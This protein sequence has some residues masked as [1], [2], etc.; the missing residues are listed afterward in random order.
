M[1]AEVWLCT[2]LPC[3]ITN[4]VCP[5]QGSG[6]GAGIQGKPA[7]NAIIPGTGTRGETGVFI[8]KTSRFKY[9]FKYLYVPALTGPP[10][11][12]K[13]E[14]SLFL[15]RQRLGGNHNTPNVATKSQSGKHAGGGL[16][17]FRAMAGSGLQNS[18][19]TKPQTHFRNGWAARLLCRGSGKSLLPHNNSLLE[20]SGIVPATKVN[21]HYWRLRANWVLLFRSR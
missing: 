16:R 19:P 17:C 13:R 6:V 10:G 9:F 11:F 7:L 21:K 8:L 12:F 1:D 5:K 20:T 4:V 3:K 14:W 2:S 15:T 18:I